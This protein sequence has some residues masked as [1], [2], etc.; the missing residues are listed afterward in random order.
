[1]QNM[2][3]CKPICK[4]ICTKYDI[5]YEKKYAEYGKNMQNMLGQLTF[6]VCPK[7]CKICNKYAK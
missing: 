6:E 1:M 4:T 2:Q 3:S 5:K 7:I